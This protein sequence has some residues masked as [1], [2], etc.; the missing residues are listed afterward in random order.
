[1]SNCLITPIPVFDT[2]DTGKHYVCWCP[3]CEKLHYHGRAEGHRV[4]HC[5]GRLLER[6]DQY[7]HSP[8]MSGY[9]LKLVG[10]LTKELAQTFKKRTRVQKP[11]RFEHIDNCV[12]GLTYLT[13]GN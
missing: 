2:Y 1:M 11:I 6:S 5:G 9:V 7:I 8:F 3:F 4:R 10:P 12:I 13:E